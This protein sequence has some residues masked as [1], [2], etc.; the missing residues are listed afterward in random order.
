MDRDGSM[1]F[2]LLP[3]FCTRRY[4]SLIVFT[5]SHKLC[6]LHCFSLSAPTFF[7]PCFPCQH[8]VVF[9]SKQVPGE[10][11]FGAYS[12]PAAVCHNITSH[13]VANWSKMESFPLWVPWMRDPEM[14]QRSNEIK[15]K[16][17][18][19][20]LWLLNLDISI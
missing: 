3:W 13:R 1:Y 20:K 9:G 17:Q 10:H 7:L 8:S 15:T 19:D 5:F 2:C 11:P 4:S 12:E 6:F 16:Q 18:D 14:P